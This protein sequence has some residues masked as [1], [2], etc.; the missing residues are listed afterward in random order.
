M[1][2]VKIPQLKMPADLVAVEP[3]G[4]SEF[5]KSLITASKIALPK[6]YLSP[7]QIEMYLRCP[8]QYKL[9]YVD[10]KVSPPGIALVE[11]SSHH[12]ALATNNSNKIS[13]G[14]DLR[15]TEVV[16]AFAASFE[17]RKKEIEDWEGETTDDVIGRGRKMIKAYMSDFA[18]QFRPVK[19][20]FDVVAKVGEVEVRGITDASGAVKDRP[21]IVDYK[22]VSRSKSQAELESSLQLSFYA[23]V[24]SETGDT[25]FD[26]GYVNL[27]KSGKVNPQF[28]GYDEKR[29]KWFRAVALSVA[30]AISLGNF[31]LTAPESWCCSE[32]F[33]GYW[34]QCRGSCR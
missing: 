12:E 17:K 3:A 20:E 4:L 16:D 23:M 2:K 15:E 34:R 8:M 31:P 33:C 22:T 24:E 6:G 13:T 26:V 29:V 30:N 11:G 1:A 25:D 10:G 28:I 5:E 9:R 27:L 18:G 32:R 21:T 14:E 7:S 19:Q